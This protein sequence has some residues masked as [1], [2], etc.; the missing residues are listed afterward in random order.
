MTLRVVVAAPFKGTGRDRMG[1]QAFVVALSLDRDWVSPDQAKRLVEV[2]ERSGLIE[3]DEDDLVATF[4]YDE[5]P[6]PDDF[7]PDASIFQERSAFERVLDAL[8]DDGMDRQSAVAAINERQ[9]DL[10]VTAEVA[11]VLTARAEGV[12]VP[13]AA[14]K[15][16][17]SVV[18]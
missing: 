16:H 3:R 4:P 6:I 10:G 13:E 15:A 11:A 2:A 7:E 9:R 17:E 5:V 8:V 14:T 1:E 18:R 12:D